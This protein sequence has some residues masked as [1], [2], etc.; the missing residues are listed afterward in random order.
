M[1][2]KECDYC[3]LQK[4]EARAER[5]NKIIT[6]TNLGYGT[7][8]YI[9][10]TSINVSELD[11]RKLENY[12]AAH[13]HNLS[14]QCI[15]EVE[16]IWRIIMSTDKAIT[17]YE[18]LGKL[19]NQDAVKAKF[20]QALGKRSGAFIASL[21]SVVSG[22]PALMECEPKTILAGAI[23]AAVLD[24]PLVAD[25]GYACLVPYNNSKTGRKE[26]QFQIMTNGLKQLALRT[27]QY[28]ILNTAKIYEGQQVIE[29]QLT[30][31]IRLNGHRTS[32]K[33]IGWVSYFKL[34]SGF[35][36]FFYMTIEEIHAHGKR[37]SKSYNNAAGLWKTNPEVM[38][39]KTVTKLNL[40]H[41]GMLSATMLDDE[42][43]Y[44]DKSD[45]IDSTFSDLPDIDENIPNRDN[46]DTAEAAPT[47]P[48]QESAAE[49]LWTQPT[50][51]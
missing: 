16:N 24:L 23:K 6:K 8:V 35:E 39:A 28:Q 49:M 48:I 31:Q 12:H 34:L 41:N 43:E 26:A 19:V 33:V 11:Y 38:E 50:I 21:M 30:G 37:Y 45:I 36:K 10:P 32:D 25:L 51:W 17:K 4:I 46:G 3:Q 1:T 20:E 14:N 18:E 5:E 22:S 7:H 15:C 29:D 47:E 27:K 44:V 9:H 42:E 40:K 13:L 2:K